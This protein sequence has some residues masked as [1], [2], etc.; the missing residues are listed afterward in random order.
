MQM[1][2]WRCIRRKQAV[3]LWKLPIWW[4]M[5]CIMRFDVWIR[6][7]I[8]QFHAVHLTYCLSR[9]HDVNQHHDSSPVIF[10]AYDSTCAFLLVRHQCQMLCSVHLV[11]LIFVDLL[12]W[13]ELADPTISDAFDR[14]VEQGATRIIISP[15]FLFPG[16]HWDKVSLPTDLF[17]LLETTKAKR[18]ELMTMTTTSFHHHSFLTRIFSW[19][20]T[21][22]S[23]FSL[24][25][26]FSD[27]V[28]MVRSHFL[29]TCLLCSI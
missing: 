1:N 12:R 17:H 10:I 7:E 27:F 21:R 26:N 28:S 15:Y 6:S 9:N 25:Q 24:C 29:C 18:R 22:R 16:R 4:A 14:C 3:W 2:S 20:E 13:Q 5:C 8:G 11:V 23:V 19:R